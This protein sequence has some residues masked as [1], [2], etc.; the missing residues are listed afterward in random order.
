MGYRIGQIAGWGLFCFSFFN[1]A[2]FQ[3]LALCSLANSK[4][5]TQLLVT[6]VYRKRSV[7]FCFVEKFSFQHLF[8]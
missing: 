1:V 5:V 8:T 3:R 4:P 2:Q 7:Y 6:E